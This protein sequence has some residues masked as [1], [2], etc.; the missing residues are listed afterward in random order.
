VFLAF[1]AGSIAIGAWG[2]NNVRDNLK[3]EQI[4]FGDHAEDPAVPADLWG[5]QVTTALAGA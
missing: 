3:A 2:I 4:Y 1:G 5:K